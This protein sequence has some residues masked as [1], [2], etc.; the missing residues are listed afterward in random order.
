MDYGNHNTID[1]I[2]L[3]AHIKNASF[4]TNVFLGST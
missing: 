3:Y 4:L 1:I 2:L